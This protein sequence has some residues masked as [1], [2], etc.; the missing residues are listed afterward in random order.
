M[1][2]STRKAACW[3]AHLRPLLLVGAV[4]HDVA[5][6]W[7]GAEQAVG[8]EHE[9]GAGARAQHVAHRRRTA[10]LRPVQLHPLHSW[11]ECRINRQFV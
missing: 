6:R 4:A 3:Q 9:G 7:L 10:R 8:R 2:M 11:Q 1:L 5:L